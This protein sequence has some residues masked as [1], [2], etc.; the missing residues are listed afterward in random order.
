MNIKNAETALLTAFILFLAPMAVYAGNGVRQDTLV[1]NQKLRVSEELRST[2]GQYTLVMQGDGNLVLYDN[3][4]KGLWS[5]DTVGSGAIECVLQDDGNLV[6][7]NRNGRDVWATSTEGYKNAKLMIQNDGNLVIHNERG[8]AVWAKGRIKDSLS[9]GENL[10]A[11]EFIRSQN[12]KY[13][14]IMQGDGNLVAQDYQGRGFWNSDTVGSGAVECVLQSDGNLVLKDRNRRVLW[15]TNTDGYPNARLIMEDDGHVV[16]YKEGGVAF[17]SNGKINMGIKPDAPHADSAE[18][19]EA[20]KA[21]IFMRGGEMIVGE[22]VDISSTRLVLQL[23]DGREFALDRIW[24]INF[25]STGWNFPEERKKLENN[26]HYLFFKNDQITS[27]RITDFS[28]T[29]RVFQFDTKEE[30]PIGRVR[31]IYFTNQ[32]PPAYM[33]LLGEEG[34]RQKPRYVGTIAPAAYNAN[35][36]DKEFD[37]ALENLNNVALEDLNNFKNKLSA[38]FGISKPWI[39][40]LVERENVPPADVYMM[41]RTASVIRQPIGTVEKNYRANRGQGWGVI[42]KRLGIKPGSKEFHALK[43]DDTGLLS[44]GKNQGQKNKD[45]NKG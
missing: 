34:T 39:E 32:L 35:T 43:N 27:G 15:A 42:A 37:N 26:E 21:A 17:W 12:R 36:G 23:K 2:N 18:D 13:T 24:M 7:K 45:K 20:G 29:R 9:R 25:I 31:R 44:K 41:A 16:L 11:N 40:D 30:V 33:S 3:Q 6:L 4:G 10:L 5:S 19:L 22:V 28:S 1:Q 14:L 8:L 38:T